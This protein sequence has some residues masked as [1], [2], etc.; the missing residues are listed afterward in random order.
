MGFH[1]K[2]ILAFAVLIAVALAV[3]FLWPDPEA[4]ELENLVVRLAE[5]AKKGDVDGCM[6][7]VHPDYNSRGETY[8]DVDARARQYLSQTVY[9]GFEMDDLG[10][11]VF[12]EKARARFVLTVWPEFAGRKFPRTASVTLEFTRSGG[13]WKI[14]GYSVSER[15]R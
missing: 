15:R 12:G 2:I 9:R 10:V 1:T 14:I 5:M 7:H 6:R 13:G 8:E 11:E 3:L 4:A